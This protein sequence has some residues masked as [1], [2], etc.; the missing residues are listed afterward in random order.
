M[1]GEK[2]K[3]R[4]VISVPGFLFAITNIVTD[5]TRVTKK[6]IRFYQGKIF[7]CTFTMS[8][9]LDVLFSILNKVDILEYDIDDHSQPISPIMLKII[10][11]KPSRI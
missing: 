8:N 7:K 6:S 2:I 9:L 3:K 11:K 4:F 5:H 1:I 10:C